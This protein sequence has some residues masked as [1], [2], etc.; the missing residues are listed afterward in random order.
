VT[1]TIENKY[2]MGVQVPGKI[3]VLRPLPTLMSKREALEIAAYLVA[4]ADDKYGAEGG[5][6]QKILDEVIDS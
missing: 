4:L 1:V 3:V 6:F 2:M 5:E